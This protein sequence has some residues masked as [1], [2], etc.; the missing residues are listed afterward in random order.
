MTKKINNVPKTPFPILEN[1]ERHDVEKAKELYCI[2][3]FNKSF[4]ECSK[5]Q[6]KKF[7]SDWRDE[8]EFKKRVTFETQDLEI[9]KNYKAMYANTLISLQKLNQTKHLLEQVLPRE[10]QETIKLMSDF[11]EFDLY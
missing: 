10:D 8:E 11:N 2:D 4:K 6:E 7:F 1:I 5:E 9:R 3:H